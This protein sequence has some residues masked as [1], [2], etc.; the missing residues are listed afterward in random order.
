MF[1]KWSCIIYAEISTFLDVELICT[2]ETFLDTLTRCVI[3]RRAVKL[4]MRALVLLLAGNEWKKKEAASFNLIFVKICKYACEKLVLLKYILI[5]HGINFHFS[6][7][8]NGVS[9]VVTKVQL[10]IQKTGKNEA[11]RR[12]LYVLTFAEYHYK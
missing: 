12:K 4:V 5:K 7:S 9:I 11:Q 1:Q 2:N 3:R 6:S 10:N 8:F